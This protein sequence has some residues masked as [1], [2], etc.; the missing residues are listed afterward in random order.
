MNNKITNPYLKQ[1]IS[2]ISNKASEGRVVGLSWETLLEADGD[3]KPKDSE[4]N[5]EEAPQK[6]TEKAG[7]KQASAPA[8]A[9]GESDLLGSVG[10]KELGTGGDAA[11]AGD[12]PAASGTATPDSAAGGAETGDPKA[13]VAKA[14]A[15]TAKTKAELEKA[16]AEKAQ[17]EKELKDQSYIKLN[18]N[19]GVRFLLSKLLYYANRTGTLETL[20]TELA[21][22]L[23]IST[24]DDFKVFDEDL[25]KSKYKDINHILKLVD[26][27][28]LQ[29]TEK[30]D[31][32]QEEPAK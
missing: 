9:S 1:L 13:D 23:K 2:E 30:P 7:Q 18:S 11:A 4:T 29:A 6:G 3:K 17:A 22:K 8:A 20:G 16:K 27:I 28:K 26:Q 21:E 19:A 10:T 32:P 31:Q 24:P 12:A 14:Q 25:I 15:D 5:K